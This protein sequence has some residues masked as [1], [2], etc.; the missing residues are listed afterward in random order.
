MEDGDNSSYS[1]VEVAAL[2][3]DN[4]SGICKAGFVLQKNSIIVMEE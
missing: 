3:I 1:D 2:L 4:G